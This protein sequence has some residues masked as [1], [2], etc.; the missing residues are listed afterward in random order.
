V[1]TRT[2]VAQLVRAKP[3]F[4]ALLGFWCF[5]ENFLTSFDG[6]I[7]VFFLFFFARVWASMLQLLFHFYSKQDRFKSFDC[8][9]VLHPLPVKQSMFPGSQ[10]C[11]QDEYLILNIW[12]VGFENGY[13]SKHVMEIS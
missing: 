10:L 4:Y 5:D 11:L 9:V 13:C 2:I 6:F 1:L 8:S 3:T 7:P 12:G